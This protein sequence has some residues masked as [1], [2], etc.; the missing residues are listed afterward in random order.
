MVQHRRREII[1]ILRQRI[2]RALATGSIFAGD[3]LASTREM[4]HELSADPRVVAAA[5]RVLET[6]G[7]VEIRARSGIYVRADAAAARSSLVTPVE[8][9]TDVLTNAVLRGYAGPE[10]V[11]RLTK[12]VSGRKLRAIVLATMPDQVLG[13]AR[14]LHED[15][16]LD[17]VPLLVERMTSDAGRR[18]LGRADL[19]ITTERHHDNTVLLAEELGVPRLTVSI[20]GDLFESE[21]ALWR[22]EPV[23][24]V[25]L[26]K[27]FRALIRKFLTDSGAAAAAVRVHLATDDLSRIPPDAPT[28]VTQAARTH[29]GKGHVPGMLIPPTRLFAA[30]CVRALWQIIG[31]LNLGGRRS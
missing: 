12:M 28:Y 19:I 22:G 2:A 27:R 31:T 9:L 13:L 11:A 18:M 29:I 6:E 5:F 20:R 15:F 4:A 3:R 16:G 8:T 21:W 1:D 17:A 26:D 7:L 25:V 30:D 14:E 23:H 24:I 10:F